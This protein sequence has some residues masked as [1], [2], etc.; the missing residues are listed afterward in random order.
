VL[1]ASTTKRAKVC[2]NFNI[3]Q[4]MMVESTLTTSMKSLQYVS[5]LSVHV[6]FEKSIKKLG[7]KET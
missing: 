5:T 4:Y 6:F 7:L 1:K 2:N 3:F